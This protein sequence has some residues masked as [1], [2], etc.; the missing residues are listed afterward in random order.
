MRD[1]IKNFRS[2]LLSHFK[3]PK[4]QT[5]IYGLISYEMISYILWGIG[6]SVV[7]IVS[8]SLFTSIG[9]H[10]LVSNIISTMFAIIF[11]Y[12]TNKIWVFKSKTHGICEVFWE[13]MR[14]ANARFATLIMTEVILLISE[15]INGNAYLAKLLAMLITIILNYIFSKLFI[16][17]NGKGIQNVQQIN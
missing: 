4:I 10:A 9:L 3:Q 11:A 7:D 8:F 16:F 2:F 5:L 12:T 1:K 6:T 17:N 13:F 15:I 14:F